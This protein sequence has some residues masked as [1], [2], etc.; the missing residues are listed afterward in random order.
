MNS[1]GGNPPHFCF[2]FPLFLFLIS[3]ASSMVELFLVEMVVPPLPAPVLLICSCSFSP[4]MFSAPE[5]Q[6]HPLWFLLPQSLL[7]HSRLVPRIHLSGTAEE[8]HHFGARK[9][10]CKAGHCSSAILLKTDWC[11]VTQ[12][13]LLHSFSS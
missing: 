4:P 12:C 9:A 1:T 2:F 7:W 6:S 11:S 5:A 3:L 10:G 13:C 8:R